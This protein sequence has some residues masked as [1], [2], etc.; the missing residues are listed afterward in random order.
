MRIAVKRGYL[1]C[2]ALFLLL[3]ACGTR[4]GSQAVATQV[5]AAATVNPQAAA[6]FYRGKTISIIVG[7]GPGGGFDTIA[8][9]V[10]KHMPR[11]M[12]GNPNVVVEN[13]DGAGSLIALNHVYNV[14]KPDGLTIGVFNE[15][16]IN[17]QLFG[18][19]SVQFD[20]RKMGWLGNAQQ[21]TT[22]C[23]IRADSPYAENLLRKDAPPLI[24]GGT[25]PG[26]NTDDF[27]RVLINLAG[28][29]GRLV[30][31]YPG[32]AQI[33]LAVE[34]REVDGMCWT[35]DSVTATAA[36]WLETNF[37]TVPVYTAASVDQ[38]VLDRFPKAIL[39]E[40][41]VSDPQTKHLMKVS[42]AAAAI[43]KPFV[44]PPGVP[45]ERVAALQAA[46][47][48]TMKDAEFLADA[49]QARLEISAHNGAQALVIVNEILNLPPDQAKKLA[50]VLK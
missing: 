39:A 36:N 34:G 11:H 38:R 50:D 32:T 46:F 10:S 16:Q 4:T 35:W 48:S 22:A 5:P 8:R 1:L 24:F 37:I 20:L 45:A 3:A 27:A 14:A 17:N 6:D 7:L 15:L 29:N 2:V 43:S 42:Q 26:S 44:L 18:N 25:G 31:G 30:S 28:I 12:P 23:T 13:M 33:R 40:D 47:E 41:L 19:E 9:L 49:Q 21:G